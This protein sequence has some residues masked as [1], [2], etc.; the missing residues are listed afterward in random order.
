MGEIRLV[1]IYWLAGLL[2]GEGWFGG[3]G[4]KA[5]GGSPRIVLGMTDYDVVFRAHALLRC[6]SP[7]RKAARDSTRKPCYFARLDGRLAA[8]WLM[9][10]YT[11]MGERRQ[12][13]IRTVLAS[14]RTSPVTQG[15]MYCRRGHAFPPYSRICKVCQTIT[16]KARWAAHKEAQRLLTHPDADD[17]EEGGMVDGRDSDQR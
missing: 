17:E 12:Q 6:T 11:F 9:T 13:R 3:R 1:D 14:W 8:G 4:A 10:L 7:I 5:T 2:E 15:S 16:A